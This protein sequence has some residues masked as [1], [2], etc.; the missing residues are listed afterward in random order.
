MSAPR[1]HMPER[2]ELTDREI[3]FLTQ[4]YGHSMPDVF[5]DT[6]ESV[7]DGLH[8]AA[9]RTVAPCAN[10]AKYRII[11]PCAAMLL[12]VYIGEFDAAIDVDE[13]FHTRC[14]KDVLTY[15]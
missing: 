9:L 14:W 2:I 1:P 13:A 3:L 5:N 6:L 8:V 7:F 15:R 12:P 11:G 4:S 10:C